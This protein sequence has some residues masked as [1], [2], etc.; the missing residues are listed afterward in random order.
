MDKRLN[1]IVI[2]VILML[3]ISVGVFVFIKTRKIT[4]TVN[5]RPKI[6]LSPTPSPANITT[7]ESPDGKLILTVKEKRMDNSVNYIFSIITKADKTNKI[8]YTSTLPQG[9]SLSV[10]FNTFSPDGKFILL[11]ETKATGISFLVLSANKELPDSNKE[12]IN[13]SNLF[14]DKYSDYN[15]TEVTGWAGTSLIVMNSDKKTGGVG[16]SFWYDVSNNSFIKLSTRF[17]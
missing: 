4:E 1:L 15:I 9:T 14:N 7:I 3:L 6:I 16:P 8:I 13:L 12:I 11:K 10:L 2:I 17:N 5:I